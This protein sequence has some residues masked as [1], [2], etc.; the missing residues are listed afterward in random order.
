MRLML[1]A[2]L[3]GSLPVSFVP[4]ASGGDD[5][6][7]AVTASDSQQNGVLG[8]RLSCWTKQGAAWSRHSEAVTDQAGRAELAAPPPPYTLLAARAG[9]VAQ[10]IDVTDARNSQR[11]SMEPGRRLTVDAVAVG[12]STP[13]LRFRVLALSED[14]LESRS[15][16]Q[17]FA[18]ETID[19]VESDAETGIAVVGGIDRRT[20]LLLVLA[21]GNSPAFVPVPDGATA[22]VRAQLGASGCKEYRVVDRSG[23]PVAGARAALAADLLGSW[24][25]RLS[26][27][28][29]SSE[30]GYLTLCRSAVNTAP[31]IVAHP[32][33]AARL[34]SWDSND[35]EIMLVD[36]GSLIGQALD[37][38]QMPLRGATVSVNAL[39]LEHSGRV[40][41]DGRF[42]LLHL[43]AGDWQAHLSDAR[44]PGG[45]RAR[46][47]I[48]NDRATHVDFAPPALQTV[49]LFQN[50]QPLEQGRVFLLAGKT[51]P[52][53]VVI[54][55][56]DVVHG[57]T[58]LPVRDA[59]PPIRL[60]IR[61]GDAVVFGKLDIRS[62]SRAS[63]PQLQLKL[64]GTMVRG[65]VVA[66]GTR[67]PLLGAQL[68][69]QRGANSFLSM[70]RGPLW[71]EALSA[72]PRFD[73]EASVAVTDKT[74]R[75]ELFLPDWCTSLQVAG[76]RAL[77]ADDRA[78]Q[79]H[80]ITTTSIDRSADLS[81]ELVNAATLRVRVVVEPGVTA[82]NVSLSMRRSSERSNAL[83]R[84]VV[85]NETTR[86]ELP[87]R[88]PWWLVA[89]A[90]GAA[91]AVIGPID[92]EPGSDPAGSEPLEFRLEA[93]A[94]LELPSNVAPHVV[95]RAGTDWCEWVSAQ[96]LDSSVRRLGP[97]PLGSYRV[98]DGERSK[99]V[100]LREAGQV[101]RVFVD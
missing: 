73:G 1:W 44:L 2:L 14:A 35:S 34:W 63:E 76:P 20:R 79:P 88:G 15:S 8:V 91:P 52:E 67:K 78:W 56:A 85:L 16:N 86:V 3:V 11:L 4:H 100:V 96:E 41:D 40:A 87:D 58:Q 42:E 70:Q 80:S 93:G 50:E 60:A 90:S 37:A 84:A 23:A 43:P 47:Q 68:T 83:S 10:R 46:V 21:P 64:A 36:G 89:T 74:G 32:E 27:I 51:A 61:R 33:F 97:F 6:K 26:L 72:E 77:A 82:H 12:T 55:A 22:R 69:C 17:A 13:I 38:D 30:S 54:A 5:T 98:I 48:V 71:F 25:S 94:F 92:V 9:W 101:Q 49:Q 28:P 39:G 18:L 81:I 75:F 31:A 62:T 99:S 29:Q 66:A 7:L 95:D 59:E 24:E 53:L 45:R 57:R 19:A 65:V